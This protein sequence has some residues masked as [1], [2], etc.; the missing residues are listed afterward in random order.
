MD[1]KERISQ[2]ARRLF[3]SKG[4]EATSVRDIAKAVGIKDSSLYNH[5]KNKQAIFEHIIE[6][7]EEIS[8][9]EFMEF[10][11]ENKYTD[12]SVVILSSIT[13]LK[14][15]IDPCV[16]ETRRMLTMEMYHNEYAKNVYYKLFYEEPYKWC[17]AVFGELI[18]NGILREEKV[19]SLYYRFYG[20]IFMLILECDL[21]KYTEEELVSK[22]KDHAV[23]FVKEYKK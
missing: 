18:K 1:T 14:A 11:K 20:P 12:E 22:V 7:H 19:D 6:V 4:Y 3:S 16:E 10:Y 23:N 17:E 2:E 15:L 9:K 21:K 5:Y 8:N 13:I